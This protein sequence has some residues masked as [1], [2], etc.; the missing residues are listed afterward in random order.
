MR[1]FTKYPSNYIKASN[2]KITMDYIDNRGDNYHFTTYTNNASNGIEN[3]MVDYV[4]QYYRTNFHAPTKDEESEAK[5][6]IQV[7]EIDSL[8]N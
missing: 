1:N 2:Y 5:T 4:V 6:H 3:V 8:F 7:E